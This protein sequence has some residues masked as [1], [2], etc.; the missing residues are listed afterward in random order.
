MLMFVDLK[1]SINQSIHRLDDLDLLL[2]FENVCKA[3]PARVFFLNFGTRSTAAK[4]GSVPVAD[5]E[6]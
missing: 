1:Q 5:N 3:R 2:D 6:P 4:P